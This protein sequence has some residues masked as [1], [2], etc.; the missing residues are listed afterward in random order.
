MITYKIGLC[1]MDRVLKDAYD[2]IPSEHARRGSKHLTGTHKGYAAP[3]HLEEL[4]MR[5]A[6]TWF[7][8]VIAPNCTGLPLGGTIELHTVGESEHVWVGALSELSEEKT[9]RLQLVNFHRKEVW[10]FDFK[11]KSPGGDLECL[12]VH[13]VDWVFKIP[14]QRSDVTLETLKKLL[15]QKKIAGTP[16]FTLRPRLSVAKRE[17]GKGGSI[18]PDQD[19]ILR[20][21]SIEAV[22]LLSRLFQTFGD[23]DR[24]MKTNVQLAKFR[25]SAPD[26]AIS[27]IAEVAGL[28]VFRTGGLPDGSV[29]RSMERLNDMIEAKS[30]RGRLAQ[31][32][33]RWVDGETSDP[34]EVQKID[35]N[36]RLRL[37]EQVQAIRYE[38]YGEIGYEELLSRMPGVD[39]FDFI[40]EMALLMQENKVMV[41]YQLVSPFTGEEVGRYPSLTKVPSEKRDPDTGDMF[42]IDPFKH[43]KVIYKVPV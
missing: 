19:L 21:K 37:E 39:P 9:F 5:Y 3:S 33:R 18:Q 40:R 38:L 16:E 2:A 20:K 23:L 28:K 43:M 24:I 1:Y 6:T 17:E 25:F 41:I 4:F 15:D 32:Q 30:W 8:E 10:L 42:R 14:G 27:H 12:D 22:L 34:Y 36:W 31:L 35:P 11:L 29:F 13:F 26:T 7:A